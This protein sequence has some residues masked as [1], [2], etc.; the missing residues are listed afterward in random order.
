MQSVELVTKYFILQYILLPQTPTTVM[1]ELFI[2]NAV[3]RRNMKK[4]PEK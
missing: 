1:I 4:V 3:L 2:N